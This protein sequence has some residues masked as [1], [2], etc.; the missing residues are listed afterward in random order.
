MSS[1]EDIS[2]LSLD[3]TTGLLTGAPD[4]E[5]VGV[6][7][8]T[9]SVEDAA[10]VVSTSDAISL[11]VQNINDPVYV[12][13]GQTS[14]FRSDIENVYQIKISDEDLADSYSFTANNL[15]SWMSLDTST[16]VLSGSPTRADDSDYNVEVTVTDSGG[17]IGYK[18]Y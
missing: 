13:D 7:N 1:D 16:G 12:D 3:A 14:M 9:F 5:Q 6:Y 15:P 2:W 8:I 10:G 4:D 11:T 18:G 17:V